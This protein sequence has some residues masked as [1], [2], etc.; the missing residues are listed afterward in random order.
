MI[1]VQRLDAKMKD[2]W[3]KQDYK[4]LEENYGKI[5]AKD[6]AIKLGKKKYEVS[7]RAE[8]LGFKSKLRNCWVKGKHISKETKLKLSKYR[9][10]KTFEELYGKEKADEIKS[11]WNRKG[12]NHPLWNKHHSKES[13]QKMRESK[14]KMLKN[15]EKRDAYLKNWMK[16]TKPY[17]LEQQYID[18]FNENNFPFKFVGN[19]SLIINGKMPDFIYDKKLVEVAYR[20][21][22]KDKARIEGKKLE[23]LLNKRKKLFENEGYSCLFLWEDDLNDKQKLSQKLNQFL[24]G[25]D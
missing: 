3:T 7:Y 16:D 12:K 13:K 18:F 23:Y 22:K 21:E 5:T 8:K 19:G 2:N 1:L 25:G 10:G 6:I 15:P 24:I 17:K 11:K 14:V 9:K 20:K 4:F